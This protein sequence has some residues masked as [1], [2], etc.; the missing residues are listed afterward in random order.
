MSANI[1]Q[2]LKAGEVL[3]SDGAMGTELQKRGLQQGECPEAINIERPEIVLSIY[4]DYYNAG[5]D[6][7]ETNTFGGNRARLSKYD[8]QDKAYLFNKKGAELAK[9]VCPQGKYVAGSM[10]PTGEM[11][12][13]FGTLP[14][15]TAKDYFKEQAEALAEGGADVLFIETMITLE[16]ITAAIEA[17]KKATDLPVAASFTFDLTDTGIHTA[18]GVD[19]PTAV[20]QL[21]DS[22]AD[23]IGANCGNGIDVIMETVKIMRPLTT[24]PILA[25]PN[26]G[27]PEIQGDLIV[28]LETPESIKD[29]IAA[30]LEL[31]VNILGGCCGTNPDHIKMMRRLIDERK[32]R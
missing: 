21:T 16:E 30:L 13:P 8:L 23:I 9:S 22:G 17:A 27:M 10:G 18:W 7:A 25:Q 26:A 31:G 6:I 5:S 1:L 11:L 24:L 19:V 12:E 20:Q 15:Q 4:R 2:R 28:Y 14:I 3:L 32:N 29:K